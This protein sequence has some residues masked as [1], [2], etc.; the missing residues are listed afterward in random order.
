MLS[1]VKRAYLEE[2]TASL[3]HE[4]LLEWFHARTCQG[5]RENT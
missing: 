1:T 3:S 5:G 2:E 4:H